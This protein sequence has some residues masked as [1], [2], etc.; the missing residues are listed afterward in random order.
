MI[1]GIGKHKGTKP[2]NK[3]KKKPSAFIITKDPDYDINTNVS[4]ELKT[5]V[6]LIQGYAEGLMEDIADDAEKRQFYCQVIMDEAEKMD[7]LI[8]ELLDLS[9]LEQGKFSTAKEKFNLSLL[10][11]NL[12]NKYMDIMKEKGFSFEKN[13][14]ENVI[15]NADRI[16][17]EQVLTNYLVNVIR[18]G[19]EAPGLPGKKVIRIS[20]KEEENRVIFSIYNTCPPIPEEG[21]NK[22]W[23]S[24][25]KRNSART[26]EDHGTG[27]GL[28]IV[29][30]IQEAQGFSCGVRNEKDGI[31]FWCDFLKE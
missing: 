18:H 15:I 14:P 13:I 2:D 25:Y 29:R 23:Q 11:E 16:R 12:I 21:L 1:A 5:P 30:A 24:F 6:F 22:L 19:N 7:A 26:R 3:I 28:A 31:L 4:H 27:L 8:K 20:L 10:L 17:T 9:R